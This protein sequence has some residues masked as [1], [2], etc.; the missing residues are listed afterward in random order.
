M[1]IDKIL[2]GKNTER[3]KGPS[4]GLNKTKTINFSKLGRRQ[5]IT[6]GANSKAGRKPGQNSLEYEKRTFKEAGSGQG[7]DRKISFW[8]G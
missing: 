4:G 3:K 1:A 7:E 2:L 8:I 6:L 5:S